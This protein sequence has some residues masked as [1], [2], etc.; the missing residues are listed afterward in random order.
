LKI[1]KDLLDIGDLENANQVLM[2]EWESIKAAS[3]YKGEALHQ[4]W[5]YHAIAHVP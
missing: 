1:N 2:K 3:I 5:N 4:N